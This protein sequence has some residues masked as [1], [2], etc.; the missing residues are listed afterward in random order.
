[1]DRENM[2]IEEYKSLRD[3]ILKRESTRYI[4]LAFT[5][6]AVGTVIGTTLADRSA[7]AQGTDYRT[8]ALTAFA[9]LLIIAALML[10]RCLTQQ[11]DLISG[12]IRTFIEEEMKGFR[13]ESLLLRYR[14]MKRRKGSEHSLPMG[15][16]KPLTYYYVILTLLVYGLALAAGLHRCW[17]AIGLLS[18]LAAGSCWYAYDLYFRKTKGWKIDWSD[19][20][21]PIAEA[22]DS[23]TLPST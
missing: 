9:L 10:T 6:T 4:V 12:Y 11:M 3:E 13:W 5:I 2:L 14:Q 15:T 17:Y 20:K 18:V 8:F 16:S 22:T 7:S 23:R 1:M 19:M 21:E